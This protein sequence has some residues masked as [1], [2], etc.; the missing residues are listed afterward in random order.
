M[1]NQLTTTEQQQLIRCEET[2]EAG[3]KTFYEVGKALITIRD[4]KLYR[5]EYPTF[6][7]YCQDRWSMGRNYA[8]KK[9]HA[10]KMVDQISPTR[11]LPTSEA[12]LRPLALLSEAE[13]HD[14]WEQAVATVQ[15]GHVTAKHV[16]ATVDRFLSR[17][18]KTT[19]R[20][21]GEPIDYK[22]LRH[23]PIN[24]LGVVFLFGIMSRD[25][26]FVVESVHSAFPDCSAKRLVDARRQRWET[27]TIEFEYASHNFQF[28]GH[29]KE[30]CDLIVCWIDDWPGCPVEVISLKDEIQK[31]SSTA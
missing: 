8:D 6:Q 30:D 10:A 16:Q 12:Q 3:L 7:A 15:N 14:V 22:G 4:Q 19:K 5:S 23:A 21:Y 27:V 18:K 1:S 24:E 11:L 17:S 9:I 20:Q 28:H 26:G 29:R 31:L 2:I 13:R 25:L